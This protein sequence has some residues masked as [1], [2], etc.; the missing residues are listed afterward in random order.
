M[1]ELDTIYHMEALELMAQ[2][3]DQSVDA[4]IT[5]LPYGTTACSWDSI[6]PF[7]PMWAGIKRILKP[8]GAFV[9]TASQPFT[10]KLVM[11]APE[12]FRYAWVWR[13]PQGS[14]FLDANRK[15]MKAHEDILVFGF[16]PPVYYPQYGKGLPYRGFTSSKTSVYGKFEKVESISDGARFPLSVLDYPLEHGNHPSRKPVALYEY[17]IRTYTQAGETVLDFCCGSGTTAIAARNTGRHF[18]AGDF[19]LEYVEIA[20]KRLAEPWTPPL[21]TDET[22]QEVKHTQEPLL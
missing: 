14:N 1:I 2:L 5:D 22:V 20:R 9:T 17:L 16:Q 19:T 11:S 15:P 18:I 7:E 6:I 4:I 8:R 13:K 21:F 10:S 12:W 3:P